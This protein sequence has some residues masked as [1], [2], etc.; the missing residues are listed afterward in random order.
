M[1]IIKRLSLFAIILFLIFHG[2]LCQ[3]QNKS[4]KIDS[5][6]GRALNV[7]ITCGDACDQDYIRTE[8]NYV[9]YMQ[10][11]QDADVNILI[12]EAETGSGGTE[13]TLEFIGQKEY[14]NITDT[15]KYISPQSETD[16]KIRSGLVRVLKMG[17]MRYVARTPVARDI[18]IAYGKPESKREIIDKWNNWIFTISSN[19]YFQGEK[20]YKSAQIYSNFQA[21]RVTEASKLSLYYYHNYEEYKYSGDY[22]AISITRENGFSGLYVISLDKHWSA[23]LRGGIYI[24]PHDNEK[25]AFYGG[26]AVEYDIFPYSESTR[27]LLTIYYR[28]TI[29][30]VDYES[31]TIY[32]KTSERLNSERL[33]VGL[34]LQRSW[35]NI[36]SSISGAHYFHDLSKNNLQ[37]YSKFSINI[38]KG[39]TF[40]ISGTA[41]LVHDQLGLKK[42]GYMTPEQ[43]ILRQNQM[44]TSYEYYTSIGISYSFG[45]KY[46][47][48]V[49]PRME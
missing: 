17:L 20:T 33:T 47:N 10:Q 24:S 39:L 32:G 16:D 1:R 25:L 29:H 31:E 28:T 26:P 37:L 49:N 18:S 23:G 6:P 12:T 46:N 27:R 11:R 2:Q 43:V 5:L 21:R 40:D 30:F 38:V 44:E 35:G 13:Y 45:S 36:Y 14:N 9:N 34:S 7:F 41:S 4:V 3:A 42:E 19:S 48:I 8:I 22:K 15:L